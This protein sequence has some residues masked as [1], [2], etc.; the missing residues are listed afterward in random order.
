MVCSIAHRYGFTFN[1]VSRITLHAPIE[2]GAALV[3][4]VTYRNP[5]FKD[6]TSLYLMSEEVAR[7]IGADHWQ[8]AEWL[9][10]I[11]GPE[12]LTDIDP[13]KIMTAHNAYAKACRRDEDLHLA[14]VEWSDD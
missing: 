5:H 12:E 13:T 10:G 2:D 3:S 6:H 14:D 11:D 7:F 8:V 1:E 9:T 4:V